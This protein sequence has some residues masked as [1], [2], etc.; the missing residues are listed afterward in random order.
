MSVSN[1]VP[2][3]QSGGLAGMGNPF[4]TGGGNNPMLFPPMMM[5]GQMPVE[6]MSPEFL[7]AQVGKNSSR[8]L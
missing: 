4:L 7:A 3:L 5:G 8:L 6:M 2:T 1:S